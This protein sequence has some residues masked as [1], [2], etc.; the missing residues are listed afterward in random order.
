MSGR[1]S[2]CENG[3]KSMVPARVQCSPPHAATA[4]AGTVPKRDLASSGQQEIDEAA[5]TVLKAV[6]NDANAVD[7][8]LTAAS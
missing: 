4:A 2:P 3:S 7:P 6:L 5:A 1:H 8:A